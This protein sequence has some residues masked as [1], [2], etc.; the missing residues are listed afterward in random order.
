MRAI[1]LAAG[2]DLRLQQP[3]D[4]QLPTGYVAPSIEIDYAADVARAAPEILPQ[5]QAL[6]GVVA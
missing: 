1:V 4:Q 6:S 2:R 3:E 5:L